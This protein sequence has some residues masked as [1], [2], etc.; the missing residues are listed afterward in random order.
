M[1]LSVIQNLSGTDSSLR[2]I[3]QSA[4]MTT[5]RREL[6][7]P[8]YFPQPA[9]PFN[10]GYGANPTSQAPYATNDTAAVYYPYHYQANPHVVD[11][12]HLRLPWSSTQP[13]CAMQLA[14]QQFQNTPAYFCM[15]SNYYCG[16]SATLQNFTQ[17]TP[18]VSND[19]NSANQTQY[20]SFAPFTTPTPTALSLN[21][22]TNRQE[23]FIRT[24]PRKVYI[25]R[26]AKYA[27]N[28]SNFELRSI[29]ERCIARSSAEEHNLGHT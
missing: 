27:W 20:V 19:D 4:A 26:P 28:F 23:G 10:G 9:L 21:P 15:D 18:R 29:V 8:M 17:L 2:R 25:S 24:V 3:S 22:S 14:P 11:Q 1:Q 5:Y 6:Y 13:A 16:Q 12:E 7:N